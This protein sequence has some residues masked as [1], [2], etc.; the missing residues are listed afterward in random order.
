M[1]A[2][3]ANG[4]HT[5][6]RMATIRCEIILH[7]RLDDLRLLDSLVGCGWSC[8]QAH[9]VARATRSTS[10]PASGKHAR[11]VCTR[12]LSSLRCCRFKYGGRALALAAAPIVLAVC[13]ARPRAVRLIHGGASELRLQ[14]C[15]STIVGPV[16]C[17]WRSALIYADASHSSGESSAELKWIALHPSNAFVMM[18]SCH[19]ATQ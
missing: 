3:G 4:A 2:K 17:F 14:T 11:Q 12:Y 9:A 1:D 7:V 13:T 10:L 16:R 5:G 8:T 15:T 18:S 6:Q 19:V